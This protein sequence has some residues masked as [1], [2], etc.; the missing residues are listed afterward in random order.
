MFLIKIIILVVAFV[1]MF[2]YNELKRNNIRHD[3]NK[4][5][6]IAVIL[7]IIFLIISFIESEDLNINN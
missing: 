7:L 1:C 4:Y 2:E 6:V 3:E 5:F